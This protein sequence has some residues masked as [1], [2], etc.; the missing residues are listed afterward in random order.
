MERLSLGQVLK[1]ERIKK[2]I[3][4]KAL[5]KKIGMSNTYLSEI[6]GAKQDPSMK[7]LHKIASAIDV[8]MEDVIAK[9]TYGKIG[10][11]RVFQEGE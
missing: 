7:M 11:N 10:Q 8:K 2:G 1:I 6:E 5:A 4:Q 3:S 9:S